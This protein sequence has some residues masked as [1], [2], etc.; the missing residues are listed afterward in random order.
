M[1]GLS[2]LTI[3]TVVSSDT[4]LLAFGDST[5]YYTLR[6]LCDSLSHL[7]TE[8]IC[9]TGQFHSCA[10][11]PT[12]ELVCLDR[13][14]G[15]PRLVFWLHYGVSPAPPYHFKYKSYHRMRGVPAAT[16]AR[17]EALLRT[18][19]A[20]FP[21]TRP[22]AALVTSSA[23][24]H[25]RLLEH[26]PHEARALMVPTSLEGSRVV[27]DWQRNASRLVRQLQ[28]CTARVAWLTTL[29]P[30]SAKFASAVARLNE[31]ALG[32]A[33]A[34]GIGAVDADKCV[35]AAGVPRDRRLSDGLH[36]ANVAQ[37]AIA[38]CIVA[39]LDPAWHVLSPRSKGD[40]LT[41]VDGGARLR[42]AAPRGAH[43]EGKDAW[44]PPAHVLMLDRAVPLAPQ[45]VSLCCSS[46]Y[47]HGEEQA[48]HQEAQTRE[49]MGGV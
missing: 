3:M 29:Q 8:R 21:G 32:L 35:T 30:S 46:K 31:G 38:R 9:R 45:Q 36:P 44:W 33:R 25:A 13:W 6:R 24:D 22:A 23:W 26:S 16:P 27:A 39:Q 40:A 19:M 15:K 43:E 49:S 37:D 1:L 41:V 7:R 10:R 2:A 28:N 18:T 34:L 5:T 17:V 4:Y 20:A 47:P 48:Q 11:S 42:A 12:T 14:S